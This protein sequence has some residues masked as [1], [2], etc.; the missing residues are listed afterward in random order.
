MKA[1]MMVAALFT[2]SA[3]AV[4]QD[5]KYVGTGMS[6]TG[7]ASEKKAPTPPATP[8]GASAAQTERPNMGRT[9]HPKKKLGERIALRTT[10]NDRR[11]RVESRK[12]DDASWEAS[13]LPTYRVGQV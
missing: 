12:P 10:L 1:V 11:S 4:P 5:S 13:A 7:A 9:E 3:P 6:V 8:T 2:L